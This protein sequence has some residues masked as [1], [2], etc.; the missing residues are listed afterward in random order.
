MTFG[1]YAKKESLKMIA[2]KDPHYLEWV[3]DKDFSEV[4]GE[5]HDTRSSQWQVSATFIKHLRQM[6][7]LW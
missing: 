1:K 2:K 7:F 5:E 4:R 6:C 3:L